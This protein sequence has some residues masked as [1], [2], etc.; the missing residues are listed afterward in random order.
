MMRIFNFSPSGTVQK[1]F[2]NEGGRVKYLSGINSISTENSR[3]DLT[4]DEDIYQ[5]IM[6]FIHDKAGGIAR[7]I[8]AHPLW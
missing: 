3:L 4:T 8:K 2:L 1:A 7:N 6:R 5:R